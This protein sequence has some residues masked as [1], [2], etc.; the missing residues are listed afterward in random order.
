MYPP[1][2]PGRLY[3]I[4]LEYI[5]PKDD[6]RSGSS[7]RGSDEGEGRSAG[8]QAAAGNRDLPGQ[9]PEASSSD[10][11]AAWARARSGPEGI[12]PRPYV[13]LLQRIDTEVRA[14]R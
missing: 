8:Q 4:S 11:K 1:Q 9:K 14:V 13:Q 7:R 10:Q 2:V 6:K 5:P 3:P 12:D